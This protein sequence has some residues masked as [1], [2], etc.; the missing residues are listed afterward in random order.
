MD[1]V[2]TTGVS[3]LGWRSSDFSPR[4][5]WQRSEGLPSVPEV[6][7]WED[8]ALNEALPTPTASTASLPI[9]C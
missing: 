2:R 3:Q 6:V 9:A 7:R 4:G 1:S 5:T 8:P